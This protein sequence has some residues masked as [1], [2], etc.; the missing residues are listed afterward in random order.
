MI[1]QRSFECQSNGLDNNPV[2][3]APTG[4]RGEATGFERRAEYAY[5]IPKPEPPLDLQP[6]TLDPGKGV[7]T[8]LQS[9]AFRILNPRTVR[10]PYPLPSVDMRKS[11]QVHLGQDA[12][13]GVDLRLER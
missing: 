12:K 13:S 8:N 11:V 7:L 9:H 5:N 1:S 4:G 10:V 3:P 2:P 6:G